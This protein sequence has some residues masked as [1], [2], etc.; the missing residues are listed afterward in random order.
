MGTDF[1][2]PADSGQA[3]RRHRPYSVTKVTASIRLPSKSRTKAA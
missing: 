3:V 2:G 1:E